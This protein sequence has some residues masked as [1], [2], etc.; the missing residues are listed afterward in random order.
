MKRLGF[1]SAVVAGIFISANAQAGCGKVTIAEM[2][3]ASAQLM[4][5]IDKI[6]QDLGYQPKV[7]LEDGFSRTYNWL[8]DYLRN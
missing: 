8:Q 4:A 3:W 1:V 5:N 7:E 6:F 2:N